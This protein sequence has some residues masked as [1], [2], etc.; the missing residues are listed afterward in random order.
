MHQQSFTD[1]EQSQCRKKTKMAVFLETMDAI[2]PWEQ[3]IELVRPHYYSG[4]RGRPPVGIETMLRMYLLQNWYQLSD[5]GIEDAITET[6]S[7]R[8]FMR[9]NFL[10]TQVPDSTTLLGFRHLLE[11]HDIGRKIFDDV[12]ERLER[13][14]LMMHGG[15][16]VDAT[17]VSAPSSTKNRE[18]KRDPEMH[19]TKKGNQWYHGMKV[20][21]GVDAGSGYV[22]SIRG[23]AANVHD[24]D[25]AAKLIRADD[26][27]LYGD[28]GYLGI[29]K[30]AEVL[31]NEH[32]AQVEFRINKRPSS[33]KTTDRSPGI[34]WDKHVESRK[35]SVR[36]K[37]EH[38]FQI[39]KL[40]FGCRKT[41]YRGIAKNMNRF[42][43]LFASA[44]LVMCA[45]AGRA[46]EFC[47]V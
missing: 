18:G 33:L 47:G 28:A 2:I 5:V 43:V 16:I 12:K 8:R 46:N 41:A 34:D 44:N 9:I 6:A 19:Q 30:R 10:Q 20:H 32:L 40:Y 15:T 45:R 1:V 42:H 4:K 23:T 27:V 14:G 7:M 21:A 35:S 25:E 39:V 13:A 22:H 31:G 29:D 38:V 17:I 11:Q 37:V 24:L 36:S 3:W 26:E